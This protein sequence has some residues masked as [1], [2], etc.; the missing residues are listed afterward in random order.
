MGRRAGLACPCPWR[1]TK[2][3]NRAYLLVALLLRRGDEQLELFPIVGGRNPAGLAHTYILL[4]RDGRLHTNDT[5]QMREL[6]PKILY[7][8]KLHDL[9][10]GVSSYGARI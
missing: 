3:Q 4:E 8:A 9:L 2:E 5:Q 10:Q 7:D 6:Q 1:L